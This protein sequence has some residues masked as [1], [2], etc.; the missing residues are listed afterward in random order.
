MRPALPGS[1]RRSTG[2]SVRDR[3]DRAPASSARVT[4]P[5][6]GEPVALRLL[7]LVLLV[8]GM[9]TG[10]IRRGHAAGYVLVVDGLRDLRLGAGIVG[11][12]PTAAAQLRLLGSTHS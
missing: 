6:T 2:T 3:G 12:T 8:I 5:A 4:T 7:G 9:V 11:C 10:S 1:K